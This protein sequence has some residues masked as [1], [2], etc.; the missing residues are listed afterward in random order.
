EP[1]GP[2]LDRIDARGEPAALGVG[3]PPPALPPQ[4][5]VLAVVQVDEQQGP[6]RSLVGL[7]QL[8]AAHGRQPGPAAGPPQPAPPRQRPPPARRRGGGPRGGGGPPARAGGAG[9]R[10]TGPG[11][12]GASPPAPA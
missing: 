12:G 9:P 4:R 10:G 2:G 1:L 8:P 11:A 5:G 3:V 6:G 7:D